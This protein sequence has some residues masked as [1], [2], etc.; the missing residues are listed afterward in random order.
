MLLDK[1]IRIKA[2]IG[3]RVRVPALELRGAVIR[4]ILIDP[5]GV[6]YKVSYFH[7][8]EQKMAYLFPDEIEVDD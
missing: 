3:G 2:D 5:E 1:T 8:G 6:Q 4:A 7:A